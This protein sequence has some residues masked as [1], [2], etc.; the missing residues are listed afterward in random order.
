[1]NGVLEAMDTLVE[2]LRDLEP[3]ALKTET[4]GDL[5]ARAP[6]DSI[7]HRLAAVSCRCGACGGLAGLFFVEWVFSSDEAL[8]VCPTCDAEGT[9]TIVKDD[10]AA[11]VTH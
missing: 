10:A 5:L 4:I 9:M 11:E 2:A 3:P 1:M 8:P 6:V 7:A